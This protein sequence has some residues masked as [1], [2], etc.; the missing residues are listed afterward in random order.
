MFVIAA[1]CKLDTTFGSDLR[2]NLTENKPL[3]FAS[4]EF[5]LSSRVEKENKQTNQQISV[6]VHLRL[7]ACVM[8]ASPCHP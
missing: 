4:S 6:F 5:N 3:E 2:I 7:Y 1:S 8:L